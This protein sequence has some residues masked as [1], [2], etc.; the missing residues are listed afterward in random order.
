MAVAVV[1][2]DVLTKRWALDRLEIGT[3][4]PETCIDVV[5]TLRFRLHFNP[6]ASFG[7]ATGL[8]RWFGVLAILLSGWLLWLSAHS[9]R[10]SL[11][12]L[13]GLI[14]GGAL[15]NFLDRLLRAEDGWLSGTVG[16]FIDFQWWP[17]FNVADIAI[18]GGVIAVAV[19]QW[20]LTEPEPESELLAEAEPASADLDGC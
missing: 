1:V 11:V 18:V 6:G 4:T 12:V 7:S 9:H 19:L 16:D 10:R 13:Y 8:G 2:V 15:G 14:V 3:C 17:I 5:W 20:F